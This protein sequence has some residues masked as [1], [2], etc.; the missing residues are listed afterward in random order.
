MQTL[1]VDKTN[2]VAHVC[3][4]MPS[5]IVKHEYI[6]SKGE[7]SLSKDALIR[8]LLCRPPLSSTF[9]ERAK[10]QHSLDINLRIG[11]RDEKTI[12]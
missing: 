12:V 2:R 8:I 3:D 10:N 4:W 1:K 6:L 11:K 7:V 5:K 9:K